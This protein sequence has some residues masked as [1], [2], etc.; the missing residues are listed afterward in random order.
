MYIKIGV[1]H[2]QGTVFHGLIKVRT[3][4]NEFDMRFRSSMD[5]KKGVKVYIFSL[6]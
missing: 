2:C 6:L 5:L 1:T 3:Q 4:I